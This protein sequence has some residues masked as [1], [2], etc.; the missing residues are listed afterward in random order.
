MP[1]YEISS[2]EG[3]RYEITAPEGATEEQILAY[4]QANA[5]RGSQPTPQDSERVSDGMGRAE[6]LRVGMGRGFMDIGQGVKQLALQGGERVGMAE[7][8][9]ADRY[10]A[11]VTAERAMYDRDFEGD[12]LALT[13][14]VI[15]ATAAT[16]P[17]P[18]GVAGSAARRVATAAVS[19]GASGALEFVDEGGSRTQNAALGA[20]GGGGGA[21]A[22]SLVG[23]GINAARGKVANRAHQEVLDEAARHNVPVSI[24]DLSA[25]SMTQKA[26]TMLEEV[27]L[28]GM[29]RFREKQA[30]AA[31]QAA[32]GVRNT[33]LHRAGTSDVGGAIQ[34]SL[35]RVVQRAR[36]HARGLYGQVS[37]KLDP[38]GNVPTSS[39]NGTA[40]QMLNAELAKKPEYQDAELLNLLKRYV[41]DPE[42]NFSGLQQLRSDLADG[43]ADFYTGPNKIIGKRGVKALLDLKHSLETDMQQFAQN[44]D[45][46]AFRLF[47]EANSFY[48]NN[49]ARYKVEPDLRAAL[50]ASDPDEIF[51][52]FIQQGKADRAERFFSAL[53]DAGKDAVRFGI[54]DRAYTKATVQGAS[55]ATFSPARFAQEVR[56]L[57][58]PIGKTFSRQQ[59][60]EIDGFVKLMEHVKRAGSYAENPPTGKRLL[61]FVLGGATTVGAM[62]SPAATTAAVGGTALASFM[63]TDPRARNFLL[64]AS[65]FKASSPEMQRVAD[66]LD[67]LASTSA[68]A[69]AYTGRE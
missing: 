37:T 53:D 52:K 3:G 32:E 48:R 8:G 12:P 40:R 62:A 18:G 33:Y 14:R 7:R 29:G 49:V 50:E 41:V 15:G 43:V 30:K 59:R 47:R 69:A 56:S 22:T 54:I 42:T 25:N 64:A 27:P 58:G 55:G 34:G 10:T 68:A 9:A 20:L 5:D 6:R 46:D 67:G 28:V 35:Q 26:G 4:L 61:P 19:G 45:P 63:F 31:G 51:G 16:A 24:P 23:K 44:T 1:R 13:G 21:G 2:P 36:N 57:S 66:R 11:D 39:L 17:I 60:Q 65:R 38:K